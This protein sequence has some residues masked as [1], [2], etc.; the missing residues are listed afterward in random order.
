MWNRLPRNIR[1]GHRLR[2]LV[3]GSMPARGQKPTEQ[4]VQLISWNILLSRYASYWIEL[5]NRKAHNEVRE[6]ATEHSTNWSW[7]LRIWVVTS[8]PTHLY[9]YMDSDV[10]GTFTNSMGSVKTPSIT[11][12]HLTQMYPQPSTSSPIFSRTRNLKNLPLTENGMLS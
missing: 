1:H 6:P 2:Q 10:V 3:Y 5:G 9:V 8:M 11:P 4:M 7:K 12:K